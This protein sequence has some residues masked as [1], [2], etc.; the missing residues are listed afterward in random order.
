MLI[1]TCKYLN[2]TQYKVCTILSMRQSKFI[3]CMCQFSHDSPNWNNIFFELTRYNSTLRHKKKRI[4]LNVK[5]LINYNKHIVNRTIAKK[6][7]QWIPRPKNWEASIINQFCVILLTLI[8]QF[9]EETVN[10]EAI[11]CSMY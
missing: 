3:I 7:E 9:H 5:Q 11:A 1:L 8:W 6:A 4:N 10:C 2:T